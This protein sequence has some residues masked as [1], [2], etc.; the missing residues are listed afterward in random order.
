[1]QIKRHFCH[2]FWILRI[3]DTYIL[4]NV[5]KAYVSHTIM[6]FGSC[7]LSF[8]NSFVQIIFQRSNEL[9]IKILLSLKTIIKLLIINTSLTKSLAFSMLF[10]C[11]FNSWYVVSSNRIPNK[12]LAFFRSKFLLKRKKSINNL[13]P[14]IFFSLS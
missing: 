1:M 4:D 3:K 6:L 2:Q 10:K 14:S 5:K 12:M 8:V 13:E 7:L 9:N 11:F